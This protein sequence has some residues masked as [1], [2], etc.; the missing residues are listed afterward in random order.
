MDRD[1]WQR[2]KAIFD[3]A[4]DQDTSARGAFL[5]DA[6]DGDSELRAEV[7]AL[8]AS[9]DVSQPFLKPPVEGAAIGLLT[10]AYERDDT[11]TR[12]G[13]YRLQERL[14]AGGM[15]TVHRAV[16]DDGAFD[17]QVAVKLIKRGMAT[18]DILQRFRQER[19]T[20]AHLEHAHIARLIDGGATDDGTPYL[21]L[22]YVEGQPIHRYCDERK[23]SVP[24]RLKLFRTVCAAVQHAHR[25]L[26]VHRDLKPGNILV[27][28]DGVAKLVDFGI[29]KILTGDGLDAGQAVTATEQRM[30]TP[31]YASPEQIRGEPITTST[32]VYSLGVILYELL[33]G[34]RPYH[35]GG[36]PREAE[37]LICD[38]DPTTPSVAAARIEDVGKRNGGGATLTP[39]S[40]SRARSTHPEELRRHLR[41]D[42]D[43][44][45]LTAMH[46]D[47]Q[48][49]YPSV[50]RLADDI[51]R[52]LTGLPV[53]AH[54][55]SVGYRA[56]KFV[57][58][59]KAPVIACAI[60][61]LSLIGGVI[62]TTTGLVRTAAA[63][64]RVEREKETARL[65]ARKAERINE[66]LQ[67]ML[68]A[69]DPGN[70]N[71][72]VSVREVLDSASAR[73]DR[74]L[75]E[76][77]IVRAALHN[78]IGTTYLALGLYEQADMHLSGALELT[79][80]AYDAPHPDLVDCLD[81]LGELRAE[82]GDYEK[83]KRLYREAIQVLD[84]L[85]EDAPIARAE[86]LNNLGLLFDTMGQVDEAETP[87]REALDIFRKSGN[88]SHLYFP[89]VLHNLACALRVKADYPGAEEAHR[90]ALALQR[91][92]LHDKH[93]DLAMTLDG[94]GRLLTTTGSY[95][96]AECVYREAL[97]IWRE[98]LA[99]GHPN[100][101]STLTN[102]GSLLTR[103][104][105]HEEAN[106]VLTE[107][108]AI[109]RE[110]HGDAHLQVASCLTNLGNLY[111][112][113]GDYDRAAEL[114]TE[115]LAITKELLGDRHER[116]ATC[117][118]NLA[119]VHVMRKD[120]AAADPLFQQAVDIWREQLG[121]Q[122]PNVAYGLDGLGHVLMRTGHH[123]RAR[124]ALEESLAIRRATLPENH[125]MIGVSLYALGFAAVERS[126]PQAA[127]PLLRQSIDVMKQ[128]LPEGHW[129][130]ARTESVL[131]DA[132]A[133]LGRYDEAEP[134]LL[135]S[136]ATILDARR[137]DDQNTIDARRRLT[138]LY[139]AWGRADEA[140]RWRD[141]SKSE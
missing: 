86:V 124:H 68:A 131:G 50:E 76:E 72:E 90:Q 34:H 89:I 82:T 13:R 107:A 120:F 53:L 137:A 45:V 130:T 94:L 70:P 101:A 14:G 2:V 80:A 121:A 30:M 92:L 54:R 98:A 51:D 32:D 128:A 47:R 110:V 122:H 12:V 99:P 10:E 24:E 85:T 138:E 29:A 8:L 9:D 4:L 46:K 42:L 16:R 77:P 126:D 44:I 134:I 112:A 79:R 11:G 1:R 115:S 91:E 7:E 108:L 83:A 95:E 55:D 71:R 18:D 56:S 81:D 48:M 27:T 66:F 36:S 127:E 102:L 22:E 64:E 52:Y 123:E 21:V 105:K 61:L 106:T 63:L 69:A 3:D 133:K 49:R 118:N 111:R 97:A 57:R 43:T 6:C 60:A 19:Q 5:D 65:E 139:E 15:G 109:Q 125:L 73:L 35:I 135:S 113:T 31:Q 117:D 88:E 23:L 141:R 41:G 140:Q 58:R 26:I 38:V 116:I 28:N 104:G 62:G 17:Q 96:E 132:L 40:I 67:G 39:A 33:C 75:A 129:R 93:P 74:E 119:I 84:G 25:S 37:R 114:H 103:R 136:H 59:H 87:Y 100:I 78:T 20:L